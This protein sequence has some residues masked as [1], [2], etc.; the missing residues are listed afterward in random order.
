M[1]EKKGTLAPF[2]RRKKSN[3]EITFPVCLSPIQKNEQ[4]EVF[5]K[6][7][8]A[9]QHN[10]PDEDFSFMPERSIVMRKQQDNQLIGTIGIHTPSQTCPEPLP[11]VKYFG[12]EGLARTDRHIQLKPGIT[13][14]VMRLTILPEW[15]GTTFLSALLI[16]GVAMYAKTLGGKLLLCTN[17]ED[18]YQFIRYTLGLPLYSP[19]CPQIAWPMA[20]PNA[21]YWEKNEHVPIV[22]P[23]EEAFLTQVGRI[24]QDMRAE[25]YVQFDFSCP[26]PFLH[27]FFQK[28]T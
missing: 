6:V 12:G 11:T 24:L 19:V 4:K 5:R 23:L 18:L 14:E 1:I 16:L 20:S 28:T 2:E 27:S 22:A 21:K 9:Y 13:Y 10:D 17:K 7:L 15:R 26:D 25:E 3:M 8:A